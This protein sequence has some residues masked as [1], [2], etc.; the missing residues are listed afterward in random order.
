LKKKPMKDIG[1]DD[2][3]VFSPR[4]KAHNVYILI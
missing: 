3:V 1:L 2:L 4:L